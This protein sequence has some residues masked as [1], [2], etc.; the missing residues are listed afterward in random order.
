MVTQ[1]QTEEGASSERDYASRVSKSFLLAEYQQIGQSLLVYEIVGRVLSIVI[2]LAEAL[3]PYDSF[4]MIPLVLVVFVSGAFWIIGIEILR[5]RRQAMSKS[6]AE[7]AYSEDREWGT[8]YIR[9]YQNRYG[10]RASA[11]RTF[12]MRAEPVIW[13]VLS[14]VVLVW[15]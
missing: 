15:K 8:L 4:R 3:L 12:M 11:V 10:E 7:S 5:K 2:I 13:I 1:W 6:I 14:A 9:S